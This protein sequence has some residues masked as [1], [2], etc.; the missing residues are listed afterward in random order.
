MRALKRRGLVGSMSR[1]D[2]AGD[3]AAMESFFSLLLNNVPDR[4]PWATRH[5][6]RIA[7]VTW[8]ERTYYRRRRKSRLSRLT[9]VELQTMM[10]TQVELAASLN[11]C[12]PNRA[13]GPVFFEEGV[14]LENPPW[15]DQQTGNMNE[16]TTKHSWCAKCI[17]QE[18]VLC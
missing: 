16:I 12:L 18:A 14:D 15:A 5:E 3:N 13:A 8:S 1:G 7:I 4:K 2:T 10:K 17:V 6:L 9:P 11:T